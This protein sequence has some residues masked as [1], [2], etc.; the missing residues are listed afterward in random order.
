MNMKFD[1]EGDE[2]IYSQ[3]MIDDPTDIPDDEP[4]EEEVEEE[5]DDDE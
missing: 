3:W 4:G 2:D 1:E 5:D